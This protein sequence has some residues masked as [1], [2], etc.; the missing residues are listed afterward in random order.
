MGCSCTIGFIHMLE[1]D[2][3]EAIWQW[4]GSHDVSFDAE[5]LVRGWWGW[6]RAA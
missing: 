2:R 4:C 3:L 1:S 6:T 5:L